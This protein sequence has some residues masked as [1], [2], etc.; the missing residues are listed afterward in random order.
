[1]PVTLYMV[2]MVVNTCR[3]EATTVL[4]YNK[5]IEYENKIHSNKENTNKPIPFLVIT[6]SSEDFG[7]LFIIF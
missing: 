5:K 4:L 1:M 3:V 6:G 7:V 2:F